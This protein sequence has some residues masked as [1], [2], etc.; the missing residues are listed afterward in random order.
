MRRFL[1][2]LKDWVEHRLRLLCGNLSKD[3]RIAITV[4][5]LILLLLSFLYIF[6]SSIYSIGEK[7]GI[8]T[9]IKYMI[10]QNHRDTI[11]I[12]PLNFHD[13]ER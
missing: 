3:A 6:G 12:E 2:Q 10:E 8:R 7:D 5:M 4:T 11:K 13:N 1:K 9:G